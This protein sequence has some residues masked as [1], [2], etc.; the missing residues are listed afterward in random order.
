MVQSPVNF[1]WF[2]KVYQSSWYVVCWLHSW[3]IVLRKSNFSWKFNFESA[4]KNHW[5]VGETNSGR[6]WF[7]G[8]SDG[9]RV[10]EPSKLCEEE[11]IWK[12]FPKHGRTCNGLA[13][14]IVGFQS[15][16]ATYSRISTE[17]SI[18]AGL[19]RWSWR[20]QI[21]WSDSNSDWWEYKILD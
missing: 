11:I 16:K 3:W 13:T 6:G 8:I 1:A 17:S 14:K 2:F 12:F 9:K 15:K 4:W 20:N 18:H 21:R 7:N 10:P 5:T 19:S